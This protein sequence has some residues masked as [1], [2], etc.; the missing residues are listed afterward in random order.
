MPPEFHTPTHLQDALRLKRELGDGA[1]FLAGGTELNAP[2]SAEDPEHLISLRALGL[3]RIVEAPEALCI[4]AC[5][6]FQDLVD[7]PLVPAA[8]K[9]AALHMANRNVRN[10]ATVGGHIAVHKSCAD[11]IPALIAFHAFVVV[12][13]QATNERVAVED[14]IVHGREGLVTEIR[15]PWLVPSR[16]VGLA[17]HS[18][19]ANDLSIVT[20]AASLWHD[21]D[22]MRDVVVAVGGVAPR[23]IRIKAVERAL[24]GRTLPLAEDIER[25]V[26]SQVH[27]VED[28]RGTVAFKKYLAGVLAARAIHQAWC[29]GVDETHLGEDR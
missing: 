21:G 3:T 8:L 15:L 20:A 7:S 11:L 23:V 24:D 22:V 4:G 27:P 29:G 16:L 1:R 17:Q 26:A 10:M 9:K 18:R 28:Q 14:Y 19:T 2:W 5:V 25:L 12:S 13:N 6:T